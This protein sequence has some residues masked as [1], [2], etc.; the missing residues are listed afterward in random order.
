MVMNQ[1]QFEAL[2]NELRTLNQQLTELRTTVRA[3][4][5]PAATQSQAAQADAK[6]A[7]AEPKKFKKAK[8]GG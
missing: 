2:L 1:G 3:I 7:R 5:G 6:A 4:A 8:G